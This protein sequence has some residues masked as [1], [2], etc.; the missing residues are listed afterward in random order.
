MPCDAVVGT[1]LSPIVP[2]GF[3][4]QVL[5]R[6]GV[7]E[8]FR[9]WRDTVNLKQDETMRVAINFADFAG[10]RVFHCH[11]IEH[12]DLGMMGTLLVEP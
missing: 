2:H 9:A 11:I 7:A 5:D 8:P 1:V 4:F 12:E 10:P 3:T 6:N